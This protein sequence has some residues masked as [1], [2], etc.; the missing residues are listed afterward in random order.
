MGFEGVG[1]R[2]TIFGVGKS[3]EG[4]KVGKVIDVWV[5]KSEV[6]RRNMCVDRL[7]VARS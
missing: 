2:I 3:G 6:D 1:K 7:V 5:M 4:G